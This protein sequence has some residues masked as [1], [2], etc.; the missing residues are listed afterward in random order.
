MTAGQVSSTVLQSY[1]VW[2]GGLT[3]DAQVRLGGLLHGARCGLRLGGPGRCLSTVEDWGQKTP[4]ELGWGARSGYVSAWAAQDSIKD[5]RGLC[6]SLWRRLGQA[7]ARG[8]SGCTSFFGG[9]DRRTLTGR[10][11]RRTMVLWRGVLRRWS[12]WLQFY[13]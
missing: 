6:S 5:S 2:R 8:R 7:S 4:W 13:L 9:S 12:A 11:A 10:A 1:G 3:G